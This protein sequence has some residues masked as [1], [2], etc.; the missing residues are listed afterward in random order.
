MVEPTENIEKE[1]NE[2]VNPNKKPPVI[3]VYCPSFKIF[4]KDFSSNF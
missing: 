1:T 3:V 2:T 4:P